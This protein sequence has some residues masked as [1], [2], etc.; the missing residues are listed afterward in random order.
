MTRITYSD[1]LEFGEDQLAVHLASDRQIYVLLEELCHFI[2]VDHEGMAERIQRD[3]SM[4]DLLVLMSSPRDDREPQ[5][6]TTVPFLN[7]AALPYWLGMVSLQSMQHPAHHDLLVRYTFDFLDTT[8]MLY[9]AAVRDL[10][11]AGVGRTRIGG[12]RNRTHV[13]RPRPRF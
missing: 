13:P 3:N 1:R 5:E 2:G 9:R 11:Q 8:W 10:E 12:T 7:L 6:L 4:A